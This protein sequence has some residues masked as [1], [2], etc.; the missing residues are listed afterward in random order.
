[1]P[2][3]QGLVKALDFLPK[4]ILPGFYGFMYVLYG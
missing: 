4:F 3:L 2:P 1:M